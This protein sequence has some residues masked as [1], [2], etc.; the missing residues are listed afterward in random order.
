MTKKSLKDNIKAQFWATTDGNIDELLKVQVF[1]EDLNCY[2]YEQR[3]SYPVNGSHV[4]N[5]QC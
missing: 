2:T 4:M 3:P 5:V 1:L